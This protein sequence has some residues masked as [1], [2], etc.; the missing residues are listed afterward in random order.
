MNVTNS[1]TCLPINY[2]SLIDLSEN[3]S[4]EICHDNC[5][6]GSIQVWANDQSRMINATRNTAK[7]CITHQYVGNLMT[8]YGHM[9]NNRQI[10]VEYT[11]KSDK[12]IVLQE[13]LVIDD[14]QLIGTVGGTMGLFIGFSFLDVL[15]K[16]MTKFKK[17]LLSNLS[18]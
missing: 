5:I 10:Q 13:Y 1:I 17:Y 6:K 4:F 15:Q 16:C 8:F 11:F 18:E 2:K 3:N 14:I 9:P 7:P 12:L